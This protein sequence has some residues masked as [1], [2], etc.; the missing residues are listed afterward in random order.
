MRSRYVA[1]VLRDE[2]YLRRTWHS[3]TC[4]EHL[5]VNSD[6]AAWEGLTVLR[7]QAGG[8]TDHEGEVEFV[9]RYRQGGLAR[10][11]HEVSRFVREDGQWYYL[12]G[13][14]PAGSATSSKT[15]RNDPCPCGSGR[16]FKK[17]CG[18]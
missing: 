3:R 9:A 14:F 4:P 1:Y 15:G 11:L 6:D 5:G 18:R 2:A 12:D 16:K 7:C 13:S 17:C 10:Q 8:A